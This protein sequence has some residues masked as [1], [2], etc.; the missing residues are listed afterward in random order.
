MKCRR[1]NSENGMIVWFGVKEP[2]KKQ[3]NSEV[4]VFQNPEDKHDNYATGSEGVANSLKQRLSVLKKELWYDYENGMPL[5]DKVRNKAII[6]A[7]IVQTILKHPD[8]IDIDG[9]ESRQ[10]GS[11]YTCY[12]VVNTIYGQIEMGMQITQ[13]FAC[14]LQ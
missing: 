7:Y 3:E 8:V 9:F 1:I 6:D 2:P 12:F 10:D 14:D 13:L 5:V 11:F 4:T